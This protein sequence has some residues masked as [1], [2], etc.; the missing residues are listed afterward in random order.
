MDV[1]EGST[2]R[3]VRR[4]ETAKLVFGRGACLPLDLSHQ[5]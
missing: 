4:V 1:V 3:G 2:Q 5:G